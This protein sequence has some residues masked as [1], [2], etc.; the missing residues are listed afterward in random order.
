MPGDFISSHYC[1]YFKVIK[2]FSSHRYAYV[3]LQHI[4]KERQDIVEGELAVESAEDG[5]QMGVL[6]VTVHIT[7][8]LVNLGLA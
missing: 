7:Q 8:A 5:S 6:K 4:A 3:D 2:R 1:F